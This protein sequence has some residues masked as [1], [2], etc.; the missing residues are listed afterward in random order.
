MHPTLEE[1]KQASTTYDVAQ[2][3][4]CRLERGVGVEQAL[5]YLAAVKALAIAAREYSRAILNL[6][7][8]RQNGS[9]ETP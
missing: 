6:L 4:C 1:F 2:M 8:E 9:E 5:I 3:E 7:A